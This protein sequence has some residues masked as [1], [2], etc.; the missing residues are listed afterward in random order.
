MKRLKRILGPGMGL[1]AVILGASL[2]QEALALPPIKIGDVDVGTITGYLREQASWNLDNQPDLGPN[3]EK[4]DGRGDLSML[5]ST[6]QLQYVNSNLPYDM[7]LTVIGRLVR[8]SKTSYLDTLDK[9]RKAY[10]GF[11]GQQA[12][13][14]MSHYNSNKNSLREWYLDMP[15]SE[16]VKLR[17]GKQQVVWGETDLLQALDIVN[18]RDLTWRALF[19]PEDEE[20]RKP[21]IMAKLDI[22]VEDAKGNLELVYRPGW[23]SADN[24]GNTLDVFGGRWAAQ[25]ARGYYNPIPYNKYHPDGDY[26]D[27]SYGFR[28]TGVAGEQNIGYSLAYYHTL[29]GNPVLNVKFPGAPAG[30]F[31]PFPVAP[32]TPYKGS[33]GSNAFQA[34]G[35]GSGLEFILPEVDIIGGSL[36]A[37]VEPLDLVF[38]TEAAVTLNKPY[39]AESP[40]F[41]KELPTIMEKDTVNFMVGFDK[42]L[43]QTQDWLGTDSPAFWTVQI[44]DQWIPNFDKKDKLMDGANGTISNLKEHSITAVTSFSTSYNNNTVQPGIIFVNDT[45]NG[46][47][48]IIPN[49]NLLYGNHWRLRLDAPIF[50]K[51]FDACT[52]DPSVTP[53]AANGSY[54]TH[55]FGSYNNSSQF[56]A[57]LT[58][59]F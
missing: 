13:D 54:C 14:L 51:A 7:Q 20:W 55:I 34:F 8:E 12:D 49:V 37:F 30:P 25:G 3:G 24:V 59:Q 58:Y 46:G 9:N 27:A 2:Q 42:Q 10:A 39:N 31:G 15:L 47:G 21:Q 41:G 43:P 28:W 23:D 22:K 35:P 44:F 4:I 45:S 48:V 52:V 11:L 16:N 40:F 53:Q 6:L 1:A 26:K 36:N 17:I 19:E 18:P 38:R 33:I 32:I 29:S 5:R 56:S 50:Y 57:R